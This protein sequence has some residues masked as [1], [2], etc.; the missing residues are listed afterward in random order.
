MKPYKADPLWDG[1]YARVHPNDLTE[2]QRA[3]RGVLTLPLY[4]TPTS[5]PGE[6]RV[7][8]S[9]P[10]GLGYDAAEQVLQ[11]ALNEVRVRNIPLVIL[12]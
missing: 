6:F 5:T 4:L 1:E 8:L 9:L 11:E 3:I 2:I 10:P 12:Q 7:H